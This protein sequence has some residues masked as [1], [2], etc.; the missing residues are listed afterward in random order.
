MDYLQEY[1][2]L[3]L[4]YIKRR[5]VLS[6]PII[7]LL[8]MAGGEEDLVEVAEVNLLGNKLR[9]V[10]EVVSEWIAGGGLGCCAEGVQRTKWDG[11]QQQ[12]GSG[13]KEEWITVGRFGGDAARS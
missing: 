12:E 10:M 4:K 8:Y 3:P 7:S 5:E 6:G 11:P 9:F 2:T 1:G 13:R